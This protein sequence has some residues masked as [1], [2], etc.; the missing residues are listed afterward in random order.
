V[1]EICEPTNY[2]CIYYTPTIFRSQGVPV[3]NFLAQ[4]PPIRKIWKNHYLW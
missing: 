3:D 1:F 4:K 2:I